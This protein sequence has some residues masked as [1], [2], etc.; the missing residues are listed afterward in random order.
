MGGPSTVAWKGYRFDARTRDMLVEAERLFGRPLVAVQGSYSQGKESAGTHA[1]NGAV[2]L[3]SRDLTAADRNRLV[4]ILRQVGFAAWYRTP[5]QGNWGEH[6]HGIAIGSS[7]LSS[8]AKN[9]VNDYKAGRNGLANKRADDGPRVSIVPWEQYRATANATGDDDMLDKKAD[10]PVIQAA[11]HGM[12]LGKST[13]T[14]GMALQ[15]VMSLP[16]GDQVAGRILGAKYKEY[17]D[18][19]RNKVRDLRTVADILYSTHANTV[20]LQ[21][22]VAGLVGAV[23]ELAK[24]QGIDADALMAAF[25]AKVD[26]VFR[27][28]VDEARVELVVDSEADRGR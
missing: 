25:G 1:G 22:T 2:D 20:K 16:T 11:V 28:F 3:R 10:T 12:K 4:K 17:V 5:D 9:Q 18:E 27:D 8:S 23:A 6:I 26:D 7:D 15:R 24:G 19:D 13:S 14:A 21:A